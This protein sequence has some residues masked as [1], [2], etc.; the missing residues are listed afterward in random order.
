MPTPYRPSPG[1]SLADLRPDLVKQWHPTRNGEP[2]P[3]QVTAGSGKK[4]WWKCDAGPDHEW[5]LSID[6]R[7]RGEGCPFCSGYRPS[8]TN[9][10]ASVPELAAQWHPTK[11]GDLTP[12]TVVAP[13]TKKHWWKCAA[14]PDH[15]W[16]A[17]GNARMYPSGCP[18]C[19]GLAVSVTNSLARFPDLVAE[20]HP[21]RNG[22][23]TP[24]GIVAGSHTK[25]WW[26]CANDPTHVWQSVVVSRV[27]GRGCPS[28]AVPGYNPSKPGTLYLLCGE[29]YGKVGISNVLTQRLAKHTRSGAFGDLVVAVEFSDGA[30]PP[31]LEA[32]LLGFIAKISDGRAPRG[33]DGYTESFPARLL[34]QVSDEMLRLVQELPTRGRLLIVPGGERNRDGAE[35]S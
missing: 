27:D 7:S 16:R 34:D 30:V 32:H 29:G 1:K 33:I 9:S 24:D 22:D 28:C 8:E 20:W 23:L 5:E 3:D 15:E 25:A 31:L 21:T 19:R 17:S 12:E 6:R 13:T 11:N 26:R 4:V 10:V 18:F 35:P 14:G 2:T